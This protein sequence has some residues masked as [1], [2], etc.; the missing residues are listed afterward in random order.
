MMDAV[1]IEALATPAARRLLLVLGGIAVAG[2]VAAGVMLAR[3]SSARVGERAKPPALIAPAK[4]RPLP[5][6][7]APTLLPPPRRLT[8][9]GGGK[10]VF[11]DVWAS[12]C[13]PCRE[14]APMLARLARRYG[15]QVRFVGLNVQ[16]SRRPARAFVRRF[17]LAFPHLVDPK[18]ALAAKVGVLGIPTVILV[19]RRGRVAAKIVGKQGEAAFVEYLRLLMAAGG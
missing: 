4:R 9:A 11:V 16:D 7:E 3:G 2:L 6:L 14:E 13:R 18:A 1:T 17:G 15:T 12:W 8:V 5:P 19:D 10:P